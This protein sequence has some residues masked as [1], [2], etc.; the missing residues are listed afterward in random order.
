MKKPM[1]KECTMLMMT[2][3]SVVLMLSGCASLFDSQEV[4]E[5]PQKDLILAMKVK[6]KLMEAEKLN[7]A[8]IH[9][10]ASN[11]FVVLNGFVETE[12]QRQLASKITG[13]RH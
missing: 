13:Q 3:L 11:G 12:D 8:A 4:K 2:S 1:E 9:V 10:E 5:P 7:A 6:S